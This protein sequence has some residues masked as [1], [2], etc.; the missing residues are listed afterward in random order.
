M[1]GRTVSLDKSIRHM[2]VSHRSE[3]EEHLPRPG[4]AWR[5]SDTGLSKTVLQ[6]LA[7]Q[8]YIERRDD[9]GDRYWETT[10][11]LWN[12]V[13]SL[14]GPGEV[15]GARVGQQAIADSRSRSAES[16]MTSSS[17]R[18][19]DREETGTQVTLTLDDGETP[20]ATGEPRD[21]VGENERKARSETGRDAD[22]CMTL[23]AFTAPAIAE[24]LDAFD[25]GPGSRTGTR[26]VRAP[27]GAV[28]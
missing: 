7:A 28:Y 5:W 13:E 17:T 18:S 19:T 26:G 12:G 6:R 20:D 27:T 16:T 15:E 22:A 24:T 10:R 21:L 3:I 1:Q 11:E 23:D 2:I 9:V 14:L 8:A 25:I 4:R